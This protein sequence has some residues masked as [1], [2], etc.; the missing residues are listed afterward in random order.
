MV[1]IATSEIIKKCKD[2]V[3]LWVYCIEQAKLGVQEIK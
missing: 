3:V 1:D 2:K